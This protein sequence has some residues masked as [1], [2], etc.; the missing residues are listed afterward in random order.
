MRLNIVLR[1]I[2]LILLLNAA[3]LLLSACVSLLNGMDTAFYPLLQ[4]FL[5]TAI[6][7]AF[8]LIFVQGGEQISSSEGYGVVV[9]AWLMSCL[10]C[11]LPYMLWG[12]EFTLADAWFESV[13]GFTT[14]GSTSLSNVEALPKGLL[15]WRASTHWLGGVG[16]VMFVL[17]VL[18]SMGSTKMRLSSVEL[19]SMAKDNFRYRTQKTL[20][21]LIVVYVGL[22]LIQTVLLK[23]V[24]MGWFDAVCNSFSTIAT[25][26]FCTRNSSIASFNNAGVEFIVMFFMLVSGLHFG[27][28]YGTLTG[29][30]NNIFKSEISKYYIFSTL[31]GGVV[32]AI[33]LWLTDIY[34]NIWIS[35]RYSLFQIISVASTTGFATADS[36]VW[37]P[38]AIVV[39]M[40]FTI[41]CAC[42]GSTAG[43][44]K[45]D[46]I[47]LSFKAM[48]AAIIQRQHPNAI[49]RVKLN[50]VIQENNTVNMAMLFIVLYLMLLGIGTVAVAAFGIDLETSFS[51]TVASM[52]NAGAGFGQVGLMGNYHEMP[53]M[54][55]FIATIMMLLGRFEIFGFIQLFFLNKWK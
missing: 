12:G 4:S 27:L 54:V 30:N 38:L 45:C 1:Y 22:T 14:T 21:I 19:S 34:P 35:L 26:G 40:L 43:G 6:L 33:S 32:I 16:V 47:L 17:V 53:G 8:P 15:F 24:G 31:A 28:I 49:I 29:K 51:M 46:R 39:L 44:I 50:G 13:S 42:A 9:G 3:F 48:K 36:S 5:L 18:P 41:Q 10:M 52:A 25:G 2:G 23:I 11:M 55:K 7:G 37:T 20:Q